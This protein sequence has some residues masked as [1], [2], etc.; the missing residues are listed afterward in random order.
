MVRCSISADGVGPNFPFPQP[1]LFYTQEANGKLLS[2]W[3]AEFLVPGAGDSQGFWD[4]IV[5]D[6]VP[7]N[8]P[9]P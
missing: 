8:C 7:V 1:F 2:E 5:E 3:T 4:D 6:F 9:L